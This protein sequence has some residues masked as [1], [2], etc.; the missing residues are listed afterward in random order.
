MNTT[1]IRNDGIKLIN[2]ALEYDHNNNHNMSFHTYICGIEKLL[3]VIKYEENEVVKK[4]LLS[5]VSDYIKRAEELRDQ[6]NDNQQTAESVSD[7]MEFE[8]EELVDNIKW[9]DVIGLEHAKRSLREAVVLPIKFPQLFKGKLKPW[10]GILMFGPPG[11]GKSFVAR[12]V[13]S[14]TNSS[15]FA[16]SSSDVVSKWQGESERLVKSLFESAR[17]KAP[18]VIFI[19]EIDSIAG[20]RN[21]EES[22]G[23]R[24]IKTELLVQMQG[25]GN[26]N[27]NVLVLGAT[28]TPWS[29]DPAVRRRFEKRIYIGLPDSED[30][31]L[32]LEKKLGMKLSDKILYEALEGLSGSDISNVAQEILMSPLRDLQQAKYFKYEKDMLVPCHE[33]DEGA[34]NGTMYDFPSS[35]IKPPP[36]SIEHINEGILNCKGSIDKREIK[37]FLDWEAQFGSI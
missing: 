36:I 16:V 8:F 12:A 19:D 6:L 7:N 30:G 22:D 23:T 31:K 1:Q 3:L 18:S 10:S 27:K 37:R 2:S 34:E 26:D 20:T 24:R 14:E 33:N 32:I 35:K 11:N 4:V 9:D 28:N 29:L 15:F 25:V 13:A 21:D 5:R 17:K